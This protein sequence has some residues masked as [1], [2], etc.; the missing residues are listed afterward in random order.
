M[1]SVLCFGDSNTWG[2][3]PLKGGERHL[4]RDRWTT[5]LQ[6]FLGEDYLVIP[7]GLN[8]RT[9]VWDDPVKGKV[10]GKKYLKPC[11]ESH[12]P[13]DLVIIMLGT[14]D[15]KKKFN[16]PPV[17]IAGGIGVLIDIVKNSGCGPNNS[18]PEILILIPPEVRKLSNF[19]EVF[20]D[21]HSRSRELP[22]V[23]SKISR[24]KGVEYIDIGRW[25]RFSDADG[26]HYEVAELKKLGLLVGEYIKSRE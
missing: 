15:L 11:L 4:Y 25:V 22:R 20:G 14:N 1:R 9:T 12:K 26:I 3:N 18:S 13:I 8:G 16:L 6:N 7:E 5:V 24:E 19:K 21:C 2:Y 23:Y 17:D 10:N